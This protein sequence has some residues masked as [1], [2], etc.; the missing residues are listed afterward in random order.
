MTGTG[1]KPG[2]RRLHGTPCWYEL[3]TPDL[4]GASAFYRDLLGWQIAD[5]GM[6]GFTYLLARSG[7]DP[8]A[9]LMA[10][11][12]AG[13]P[14]FWMVYVA[15]EDCDATAAAAVA[16]GGSIHRAPADIPGTGRFAILA[17]PQGAAFGILAPLAGDGN[18]FDQT[19]AGHGNWHEL[20]TPDPEAALTFY[21]AIFGW[22]PGRT[23]DM[24]ETGTYRLFTHDGAEIGG[25][26]GLGAA[27]VPNWLP[28]FG[29]SGID[30]A[31]TRTRAGGGSLVH[32]PMAVPGG[33][34]IIIAR[35]PQGAHFALVGPK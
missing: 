32:G 13:M 30:A 17:D 2:T 22:Q 11:P 12:E 16:A 21:G 35:D 29:A 27:P 14:C 26:S 5:A 19:K 10:P 31:V 3:M 4:P 15:V 18:A 24:G 28:Y 33:A 7:A 23:F 34:F 25:I 1:G 6:A 20:T 9:G 8:V